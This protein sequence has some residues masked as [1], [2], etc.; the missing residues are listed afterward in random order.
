MKNLVRLFGLIAI[1]AVITFALVFTGCKDDDEDEEDGGSGGAVSGISSLVL[2]GQVYGEDDSQFKGNLNISGVYNWYGDVVNIGTG[3]IT[4]GVLN[5]TIGTPPNSSLTSYRDYE[6]GYLFS[7]NETTSNRNVKLLAFSSLKTDSDIF[8]ELFK[9]NIHSESG[10]FYIYVD[11]DVTI[12]SERTA[13]E[14]YTINAFS[15]SLQKGWNIGN[16][17][18]PSSGLLTIT[19]G[20]PTGAK[21]ILEEVFRYISDTTTPAELQGSWHQ[22]NGN[23]TFVLTPTQCTILRLD[24]VTG[25]VVANAVYLTK[26]SGSLQSGTIEFLPFPNG[27]KVVGEIEFIFTAGNNKQLQITASRQIVAGYLLPPIGKYTALQ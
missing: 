8:D 14:N 6:D 20:N 1:V 27:G 16:Y 7:P 24:N 10:A 26:F 15:L 17:S 4:N 11:G 2:S 5:Y 18:Y 21:W 9:A 3:R 22:E 19:L 23:T 25:V 12:R 13:K